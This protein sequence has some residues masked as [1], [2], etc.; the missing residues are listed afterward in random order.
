MEGEGDREIGR[1]RIG[2]G[3]GMLS[4]ELLQGVENA[5]GPWGGGGLVY[6]GL[7]IGGY[8]GVKEVEGCGVRFVANYGSRVCGGVVQEG[9]A[10]AGIGML[11]IG[12]G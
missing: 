9:L 5:G 6:S 2:R 8:V 3:T 10:S 12:R 1:R 4:G 7:R 11:G